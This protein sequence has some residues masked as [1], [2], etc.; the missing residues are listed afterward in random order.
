MK[1][2]NLHIFYVDFSNI[3]FFFFAYERLLGVGEIIVDMEPGD[4]GSSSS[5]ANYR[6][7]SWGLSFLICEMD[8]ITTLL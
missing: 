5:F 7:I 6:L 3:T 8:A 2:F 1:D 4:L